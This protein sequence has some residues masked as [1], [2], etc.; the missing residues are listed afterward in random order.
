MCVALSAPLQAALSLLGIPCC[1]S[2]SNVGGWAHVFL[3]LGDGRVLDPS[4][5]QFNE[6]TPESLPA[7]YL[8][9]PAPI[10]DN[11]APWA[12]D[13][14]WHGLMAEL[15]RLCPDFTPSEIGQHVNLVLRTLPP[16]MCVFASPSNP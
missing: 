10:H 16:D 9:P 15:K 13:E 12:T 14:A 1:L 2:A 3:K 5:D 11:A 7:V 8:G 4:A 6:R